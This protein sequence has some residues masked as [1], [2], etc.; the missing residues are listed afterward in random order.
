MEE[1]LNPHRHVSPS[2]HC[3]LTVDPVDRFGQGA[4]D[5]RLER[6]GVSVWSARLPFALREAVVG[7][8]GTA[9]GYSYSSGL[10]GGRGLDGDKG[11]G[12]LRLIILDPRDGHPRLQEKIERG[13]SMVMHAPP[14]PTV[15]GVLLDETGGR[16]IARLSGGRTGEAWRVYRLADGQL[17]D[18]IAPA[19]VLPPPEVHAVN[20]VTAACM[21]PG[22][23]MMLCQWRSY[24]TEDA[25][26][27]F[28]LFDLDERAVV[29]STGFPL[30]QSSKLPRTEVASAA[31]DPVDPLSK[32]VNGAIL[33]TGPADSTGG[34][35]ALWSA[36]KREQINY[37]LTRT[38]RGKRTAWQVAE[39]GRTPLDVPPPDPD[40][41]QTAPLLSLPTTPDI[42]LKPVNV[43]RFPADAA[44]PTAVRS[45]RNFAFDGHG[46]IGVLRVEA[47]HATLV[48]VDPGE[49][50]A[51][52]REIDLST[53]D[54]SHA[55]TH[56]TWLENDR[57]LVVAFNNATDA[58]WDKSSAWLVDTGAGTAAPFPGWDVPSV[59]GVSGTG[60][61]HFV[62]LEEHAVHYSDQTMSL[63]ESLL[64]LDRAG[65]RQWTL[66]EDYNKAALFS[67]EDVTI[68]SDGKT[69][70]VVETIR[71]DVVLATSPMAGCGKP[72]A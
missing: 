36:A 60:D 15:N 55:T 23:P 40:E 50:G 46:N 14:V 19:K 24:G 65:H 31:D 29:W 54:L 52:R 35:F 21:V 18:R 41:P 53:P 27:H 71:N 8:D 26:G 61:G 72:L 38:M 11:R 12:S 6:D 64:G 20:F 70:A 34:R 57:W 1:P 56:L 58:D 68:L 33:Q 47:G 22:T 44:P 28:L 25:D 16:F 13:W 39:D 17:L 32:R 4:A 66:S 45:I 63:P 9:V 42:P 3:A 51:V 49:H 30:E 10:Q 2:G 7:E 43:F 62:V 48:L 67:P 69:A 59:K 5:C 37:R